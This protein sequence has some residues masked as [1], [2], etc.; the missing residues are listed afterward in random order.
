N[1]AYKIEDI[2][3]ESTL[4]EMRIKYHENGIP[5]YPNAKRAL[6]GIKNASLLED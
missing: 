5:V 4:R 2:E 3:V 6:Q 1:R